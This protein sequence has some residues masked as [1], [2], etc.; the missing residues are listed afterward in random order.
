MAFLFLVGLF[1]ANRI[2]ISSLDLVS[3]FTASFLFEDRNALLAVFV[4]GMLE[5]I[6]ERH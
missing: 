6:I 1:F 4:T 5:S 3:L 2:A